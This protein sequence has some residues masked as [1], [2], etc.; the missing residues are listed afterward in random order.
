MEKIKYL[1]IHCS[2]S[3]DFK[4]LSKSWFDRVHKGARDLN[5]GKVR[6]NAKTY[7][8]REDLPAGKI[9]GVKISK[10]NGRGWDR[11]GYTA[12]MNPDGSCVQLTPHNEDEFIDSDE[13]TWGV[14]G[15]NSYS[16]HLCLVGGYGSSS[17]DNFFEHYTTSQFNNLL[18]EIAYYQ[19]LFPDILIK[20][21]NEFAAKA[22]PGFDV[23]KFIKENQ[24]LIDLFKKGV[25]H[26]K[27]CY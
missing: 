24:D 14:A 17:N 4:N 22:C 20:G 12:F 1:V 16:R 10:S 7:N 11:Y 3:W 9:G 13:M 5:S 6:F 18:Y 21:H 27:H 15:K 23:E 25:K 26:G 19:V 2:A 8:S